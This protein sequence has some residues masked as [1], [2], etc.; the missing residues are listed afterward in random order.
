MPTRD[1]PGERDGEGSGT[2]AGGAARPGDVTVWLHRLQEGDGEALDRL[3]PLLYDELREQARTRLRNERLGHTLSATALVNEVYLKLLQQNRIQAGDR[4]QFFAVAG[5]TMRRILVDYA[6][7]RKRR[8]RGGGES[9]VPLEEVEAFLSAEEAG[10]LLAMDEALDRL[11]AFN[12]RGAEIVRLRFFAGLTLD[13]TAAL[14]ETSSKTV[15]RG[16]MAARAWLKKE[17]GASGE[18]AAV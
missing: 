6:R 15:Q 8:K 3:V 14:L 10:D 17:M 11:A 18:G 5:N 9:S 4:Q 12:P 16:W 2:G 1:R 7:T 13:E